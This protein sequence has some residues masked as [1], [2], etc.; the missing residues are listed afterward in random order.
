MKRAELLAMM[1]GPV[2]DYGQHLYSTTSV[3]IMFSFD[4][5][6]SCFFTQVIHR[7]E[8]GQWFVVSDDREDDTT[9]DITG[10]ENMPISVWRRDT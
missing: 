7:P 9:I 10:W 1:T 4:D 8:Y 6:P 5:D 3:N 2:N